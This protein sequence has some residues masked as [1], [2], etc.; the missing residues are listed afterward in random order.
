MD[1]DFLRFDKEKEYVFIDCETFNLCLNS[2]HNLPWQ[3][4][5]LKVVGDRKIA[6]KNFY[7]KW[8]TKLEISPEAA[9]ITRFNP[10]TLEKKGLTPEEV[11]PTIEDWLDNC[12]YIV[13]HNTL[14]FDVYL[15]KDYYRYMGKPYRH[16]MPK[17]ID[18]NCIAK[19]IKFGT[20]YKNTEDLLQYQY[21]MYHERRK[22]IR[23]NLTAMGK[24][25]EID[26]DYSKLHDAIVDL[27]LNLKVWNKLKWQ[28]EL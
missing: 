4:A 27:E 20:H 1:E 25:Y 12:D 28:I 10:K 21:K 15:I 5:M 7:I 16:I 9:R 14:G 17:M 22:G 3:I 2:C 13:G 26:H 19:G 24:E 18:T 11:F 8:D 6:E 23:T